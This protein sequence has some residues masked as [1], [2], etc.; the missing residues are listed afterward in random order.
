MIRVISFKICPFVQRVTAVLE[1]RQIPYEVDYI[2][3]S[4][5]PDWFMDISPQGQVP[6]LVTE[7][8]VSLFESDAIVE[9]IEEQYPDSEA[10]LNAEQKALERAWSYL[11]VKNYLVQCS[12]QRSP[13]GG[14]L[15]IRQMKLSKAFTAVEQA[16]SEGRFFAGEAVGRVD[17]AWLPLLHR[18]AII[19]QCGGYD[20]LE[21]FPR[22]KQWQSNLLAT[23]LAEKSVAPDFHDA[24]CQFYLSDATWL[25]RRT[26]VSNPASDS[27]C[28]G[29]SHC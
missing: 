25:G 21:G 28:S 19:K 15:E 12:A 4:N 3:L 5:K 2:S 7:N 16:L 8:G 6:V 1:A 29:R 20:F 14:T 24:F 11:A 27:A 18:A 10:V 13:D 9:Y 23:G 17:I 26:D 22:I